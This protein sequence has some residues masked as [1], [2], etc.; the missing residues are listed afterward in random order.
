MRTPAI[1]RVLLLI[2]P[3]RGYE[4]ALLEGIARWSRLHGPWVFSREAPFWERE[5]HLSVLKQLKEADGVIMREGGDMRAFLAAKIPLVVSPY[6]A[7][8]IPGAANIVSDHRAIG[9]MAARHLLERGFR[10]FAFCGYR[11]FFWSRQRAEGFLGRVAEAG[12]EAV[13]YD[14]PGARAMAAWLASLPKP[15]GVMACVDERAQQVAE[16]CKASGISVPDE[17][18]ILGVDNDELICELSGIPLSSVA[19]G[20][21]KAGYEAAALLDRLMAGKKV[22]DP[23]VEVRPTHVVTRFSTDVVA[24]GDPRVSRAVRFIRLHGRQ[25]IRVDDVARAAALSRRVLEKRFRR[26]LHRS[27]SLEIRQR[28]VDGISRLLLET[29]M[30]VS[31]VARS[32]GFEDVAHVARYFRART[33]MSPRDYRRRFSP[34]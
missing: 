13:V 32:L 14:P 23:V 4:R 12:L 6:A 21:R 33:G 18:A 15:V 1:P 26:L 28:R 8:R 9:R 29:D 22:R 19:I 31:V 5:P 20:A 11:D 24:V 27:V 10:H 25:P 30:T 16:V 3:S 34:R 7:E 17:V 2:E